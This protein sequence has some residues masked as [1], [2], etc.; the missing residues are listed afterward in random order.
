[1]IASF[2]RTIEGFLIGSGSGHEDIARSYHGHDLAGLHGGGPIQL[3]SGVFG[4]RA[5][6]N[7]ERSGRR[8]GV[9]GV[10][11]DHDAPRFES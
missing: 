4:N 6:S 5:G 3:G 9:A 11:D 8:T 2:N 10:E 7:I 1:M